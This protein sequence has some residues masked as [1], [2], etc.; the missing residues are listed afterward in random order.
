[1]SV[2]NLTCPGSNDGQVSAVHS[3]GMPPYTYLWSNG[4]V[5]ATQSNLAVGSY[6]VT[7][8]DGAGCTASASGTVQSPPP[9]VVSITSSDPSCSGG[10]DGSAIA[11][12]TGGTPP[13]FYM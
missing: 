6:T 10:S 4:A 11:S 12:V 13:Y 8:I 7:V 3:G 2:N 9:V 1:V 5:T